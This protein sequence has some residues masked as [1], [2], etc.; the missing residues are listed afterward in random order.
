MSNGSR[1]I[2]TATRVVA[3]NLAWIFPLL[4]CGVGLQDASVYAQ[5]KAVQPR[6][7]NLQVLKDVPP[8]QLI[9]A[10]QFIS[11]SL[12]VDAASTR[13]RPR[14]NRAPGKAG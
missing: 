13:N 3:L 8:D 1:S 7:K 10:M 6:F 9:P 14:N 5:E 11:A 12:G 2:L 4:L